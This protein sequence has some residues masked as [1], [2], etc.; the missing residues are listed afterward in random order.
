LSLSVS[1]GG[2]TA[3][4]VGTFA[5]N[6]ATASAGAVKAQGAVIA[7]NIVSG[8]QTGL[9]TANVS[10]AMTTMVQNSVAGAI[11]SADTAGF[12]VGSSWSAGF[13][14]GVSYNSKVITASFLVATADGEGSSPPKQGPLKHIDKW[15]ENV[16]AA[17]AKGLSKGV[18]EDGSFIKTAARVTGFL[19]NKR[20]L[21]GRSSKFGFS[22]ENRKTL[23]VKLEVSSPDGTANRTKQEDLRR[24]ALEAFA[25]AGLEHYASVG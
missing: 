1:G 15:G 6:A 9:T 23:T 11:G 14:R 5:A 18:E 22:Q 20:D 7:R 16:G 2:D 4:A 12:N 13:A 8:V 3:T 17:W 21:T 10:G 19:A 25:L 24:G